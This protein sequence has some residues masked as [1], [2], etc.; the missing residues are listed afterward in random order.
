[1]DNQ[2]ASSKQVLSAVDELSNI[3]AAVTKG[4]KDILDSNKDMAESFTVMSKEIDS[5]N[6][7]MGEVSKN[8]AD[9]SEVVKETDKATFENNISVEN[10]KHE[11]QKFKI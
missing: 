8:S 9:I 7:T 6:R 5:F 1:M 11:V 4:S 2:A 3:S 10:L